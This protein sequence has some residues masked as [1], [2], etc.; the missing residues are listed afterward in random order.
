M[1]Y[2]DFKYIRNERFSS[3]LSITVATATL[4]RKCL[5]YIVLKFLILIM[6]LFRNRYATVIPMACNGYLFTVATVIYH[7]ETR[8]KAVFSRILLKITTPG[9]LG[10]YVIVSS[11]I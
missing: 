7:R 3:F 10:D 9:K 2:L 5:V 6:P 11:M 8:Q 4:I 1:F